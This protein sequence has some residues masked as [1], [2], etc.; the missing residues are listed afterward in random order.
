MELILHPNWNNPIHKKPVKATYYSGYFYC[1]GTK[2]EDG[3]DYYLGDVLKYNSGFTDVNG[4]DQIT[5]PCDSG[6]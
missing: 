5:R 6:E 3:P 4:S 2:P 1:A